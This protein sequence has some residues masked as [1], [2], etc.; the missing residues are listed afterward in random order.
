MSN[1]T[2]SRRTV[3]GGACALIAAAGLPRIAFAQAGKP[4]SDQPIRIMVPFSAGGTVDL[5]ARV[6]AAALQKNLGQA[7]IVENKPGAG[8]NIAAVYTAH[9]APDTPTLMVTSVNYFV[10]P[11]IFKDAG[12][13]IQKDFVPIAQLTTMP[14]VF[15]VPANSKFNTLNDLA[16]YAKANPG[17]LSWGFGG[18]GSP[19]HFFGIEFEQA[20][21]VKTNPIAYRGGPDVLT[22]VV[23]GQ[24][25]MVVMS[26]DTSLPMLR[27]GK[28][29]A[30]A[31]TG[32]QRNEALPN[33][34]TA[35]EEMPAYSPLTGYALMVAPKT[36][37]QAMLV[38]LHD[39]VTKVLNTQA[40]HDYLK[41]AGASV[42]S[43]ATLQESQAFFDAEGT[44]W[45]SIAKAS[46]LKV[47]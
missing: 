7:V 27:D 15:I 13:D 40:Y 17:K 42:Q 2:Y 31:T 6:M 28:L 8:G 19:G 16:A 36:M 47:E 12:Y 34:P 26:A 33:V 29:K 9:A 25:D 18:I 43:T 46:G 20:A 37:P 3:L 22:A 39:E 5:A 45:Q 4:I 35:T 44:R 24:V 1:S 10:N 38:R 23:S 21:K 32:A 11:I 41:R 14:Y 30:I